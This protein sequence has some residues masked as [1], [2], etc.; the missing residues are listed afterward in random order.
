M[1][2]YESVVDVVLILK[3]LPEGQLLSLVIDLGHSDLSRGYM[4]ISEI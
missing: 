4:L 2:D 1:R 3:H